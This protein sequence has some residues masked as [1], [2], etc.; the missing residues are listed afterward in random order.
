VRDLL[1]LSVLQ[2]DLKRLQIGVNVGN[3]GVFHFHRT[4]SNP[5][6]PFCASTQFTFSS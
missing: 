4:I 2:N 5:R 6:N 1:I 3:D